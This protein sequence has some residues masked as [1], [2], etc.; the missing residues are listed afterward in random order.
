MSLDQG[1]KS[2]SI[3]IYKSDLI[4]IQGMPISGTDKSWRTNQNKHYEIWLIDFESV[5]GPVVRI[6][7]QGK[8]SQREKSCEACKP[9]DVAC[10]NSIY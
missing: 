9:R 10:F 7:V 1:Y 3:Y 5:K 6:L 8:N 2:N 4:N